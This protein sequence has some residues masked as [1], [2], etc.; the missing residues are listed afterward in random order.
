MEENQE[1]L[2][3][4]IREHAYSSPIWYTPTPELLKKDMRVVQSDKRVHIQ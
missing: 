3:T 1:G 4:S 2:P